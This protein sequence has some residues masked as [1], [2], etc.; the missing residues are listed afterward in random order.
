MVPEGGEW[1]TLGPLFYYPQQVTSDIVLVVLATCRRVRHVPSLSW[2][3]PPQTA[4]GGLTY[5][6]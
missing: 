4:C 5:L 1:F 3:S 2:L 6:G